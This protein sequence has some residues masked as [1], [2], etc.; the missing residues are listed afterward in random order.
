MLSRPK[1]RRS[2]TFDRLNKVLFNEFLLV[3]H[4]AKNG[5]VVAKE[6]WEDAEFMERLDL[7]NDNVLVESR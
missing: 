3:C 2:I 1:S 6:L 5:A 4:D 7:F